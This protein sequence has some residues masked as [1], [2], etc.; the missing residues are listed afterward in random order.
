[1][2]KKRLTLVTTVALSMA[3]LLSTL[4]PADAQDREYHYAA[5][6]VCG[7]NPRAVDRVLPGRYATAINIHN[8]NRGGAGLLWKLA[9]T[10]PAPPQLPGPVTEFVEAPLG[11]NEALEVDCED[12]PCPNDEGPP[13]CKGFVIIKSRHSLDVTAVYTVGDGDTALG[14]DVEQIQER[15]KER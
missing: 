4:V 5:K 3:C 12:I 7:E 2:K 11:N 13:Y 14:I 15:V 1:M 6:F 8:A 10:F 9:F